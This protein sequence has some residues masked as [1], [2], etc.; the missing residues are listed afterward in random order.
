MGLSSWIPKRASISMTMT[1]FHS[2]IHTDSPG[3]VDN[4]HV[5]Q[6]LQASGQSY[7]VARETR[8]HVS[9]DSSGKVELEDW[10]EVWRLQSAS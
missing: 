9:V 3:R 1:M 10:V 6:A 4:T 2:A 7:D 8:K 5:L